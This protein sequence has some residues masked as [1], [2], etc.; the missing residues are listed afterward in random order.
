MI[1]TSLMSIPQSYVCSSK[2]SLSNTCLFHKLNAS[3]V[4]EAL[5]LTVPNT[6]QLQS[7]LIQLIFYGSR[8]WLSRIQLQTDLPSTSSCIRESRGCG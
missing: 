4:K 5:E 7:Q 2:T 6:Y 8:V 3:R 1:S